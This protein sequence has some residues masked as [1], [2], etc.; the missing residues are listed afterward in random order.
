M[1]TSNTSTCIEEE[2]IY[3][4]TGIALSYPSGIPD[5]SYSTSHRAHRRACGGLSHI[6]S[7]TCSPY[8][9][10]ILGVGCGKDGIMK[11]RSAKA[12]G[13]AGQQLVRDELRKKYNFQVA[14]TTIIDADIESRQM[15]G[16]GVDIILSPSAQRYIPF[17]IEVK[18]QENLNI[19]AA[20]KQAED[21]TKEGRIPLLCFKRNRTEMY[22]CLK[23]TDLLRLMK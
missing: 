14:D 16:S 5:C 10:H 21:N 17:D 13:R 15:G 23:L 18:V 3:A 6:T 1:G 4:N 22:A 20:L 19:W 2:R 7:R 8:V 11:T 9:S 12:K